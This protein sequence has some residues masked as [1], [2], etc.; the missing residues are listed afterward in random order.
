MHG[1]NTTALDSLHRTLGARMVDFAGWAMPLQYPAGI[2]LEH[3]RCREKAALFDV[4]HMVQLEISGANAARCLE[5]VVVGDIQGLAP[6]RT[7]YTLM[8]NDAGGVVD[9][10]MIT[11]LGDRYYLVLNAARREADL[12]HLEAHLDKNCVLSLLDDHSLL[13]LQ[14]PLAAGI[15]SDLNPEASLQ[16]FMDCRTMNIGGCECRVSRLG[17]TGEDGFEISVKADRAASLASLLLSK[18]EVGPAGLGARDTLRLEAGLCL[19]GHELDEETTPVEAN[20]SWAIS[21][22]RRQ[23]RDFLGASRILDEVEHGPARLL[24][25]LRPCGKAPA[26]AGTVILDDAGREVGRVTSGCYGP[27]VSSPVA[28]GYVATPFN[29]TGTKLGVQIRG[30]TLD[31]DIQTLPFVPHRYK[32]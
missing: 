10:L 14:G 27:T 28:L 18:N 26:R 16:T 19:Y 15:L 31:C 22:R 11:N 32:R 20:L 23:T 29:A 12:A 25:G 1:L 17:Y 21:R 8:T 6:G 5:R 2:L 4:S 13:A 30:R 24:V 7:R 3:R 9:D